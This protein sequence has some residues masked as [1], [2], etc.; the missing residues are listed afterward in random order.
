M[1][2][3]ART[4]QYEFPRQ[5]LIMGILNITPDSFYDGGKSFSFNSAVNRALG[6]IKDGAD[7]IDIGGESTRPGAAKV[8][9]AEEK[10][11]VIP[12][13]QYLASRIPI[14]ISID[15]QKPEVAREAVK[16]GA[17]IINDIAANRTDDEMWRIVSETGAGYI[18][19]HM[20]GTPQTMQINPTYNNVVQE[21]KN[22]FTDRMSKLEE[23]GINPN[24]VILD[25]GIG[26]GKTLDHNLELLGNLKDFRQF[27]RPML[28]G[29]SRKSFISKLV[30]GDPED[31]LP[32]SLACATLAIKAGV[33]ILRV[34]DIKETVQVARLTE[35]ILASQSRE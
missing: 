34:H 9:A 24:Q 26:F 3:N 31:R 16:A 17:C 12:V 15:T 20:Q 5:T 25:P 4:F 1:K 33:Q 27:D 8:S 7:I 6:M 21:V 30:G 11:R 14:P 19:M 18:C 10:S 35:K 28:L 13:I 22:F 29:T 32:G 2:F 23:L